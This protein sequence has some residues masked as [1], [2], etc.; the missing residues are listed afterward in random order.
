MSGSLWKQS[1]VQRN[2]TTELRK[3]KQAAFEASQQCEKNGTETAARNNVARDS[4]LL[5]RLQQVVKQLK[6]PHPV[7]NLR[8]L[9]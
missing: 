6:A 1:R 8:Q 7:N 4:S 9:Q 3:K 5:L 2:G